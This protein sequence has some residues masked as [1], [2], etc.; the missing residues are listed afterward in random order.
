MGGKSFFKKEG[1]TWPLISTS[2]KAKYLPEGYILD[3]GSPVAVLKDGVDGEELWFI[4]G[5]LN[6]ILATRIMKNVLN[7]TK[8][9]QGKDVERM[10]YPWWVSDDSKKKIVADVKLLVFGK[11]KNVKDVEDRIES[12]LS[13]LRLR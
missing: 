13:T 10:P 9:I 12:A 6:T 1:L 11:V 4:L 5:W 7:H 8:N 3:S 2:I